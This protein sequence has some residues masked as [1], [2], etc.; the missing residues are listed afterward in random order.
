[1]IQLPILFL[2]GFSTSQPTPESHEGDTLQNILTAHHHEAT[3][4]L[5]KKS[6]VT[7]FINNTHVPFEFNIRWQTASSTTN[8]LCYKS[9]PTFSNFLS[10]LG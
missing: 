1:M 5:P 9:R 3:L 7:P 4:F 6:R 8:Y 10:D 2:G